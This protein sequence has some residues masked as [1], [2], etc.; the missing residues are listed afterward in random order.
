[1][2]T[3]LIAAAAFFLGVSAGSIEVLFHPHDPALTKTASWIVE[4]RGQIDLAL[5]SLDTHESSPVIQA[6]KA[7]ETR[8]RID[9]GELRVR[10]VFEGYGSK[11]DA[12]RKMQAL[13][14]LGVDVR[15]FARSA[16]MH[17]KFAVIDPEGPRGRVI[18]GSANWSMMSQRNYDENTLYFENEP[19]PLARFRHEFD[20]L[21]A[22]SR[23]FGN[24]G[25]ELPEGPRDFPDQ[26]G[27]AIHFNTTRWIDRESNESRFL[28]GEVIRVIDESR[29]AIDA[30]TTRARHP[31][32]LAALER[33]S[34]R[35]VRVRL[36]I[37][38]DDYRDVWKRSAALLDPVNLILRIKMYNFTPGNFLTRQM[39]HKF[40][41]I[42]DRVLLTGSYNWSLS[43]ENGHVENLVELRDEAAAP[44]MG[45]Y[46]REFD[47][48]WDLGRDRWPAV[49]EE[50]RRLRR[51]GRL[52]R[53]AFAP[54]ALAYAEARALVGSG[55]KCASGP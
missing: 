18:T 8:R 37:G 1:M 6:L 3:I 11:E 43:S 44:V 30:A 46:R 32:I 42:D 2:G 54:M 29:A 45:R 5:Y 35:G 53:C 7:A 38:Q 48:L 23:E 9:G 40:L 47:R 49:L 10:L 16:K 25:P 39:H 26:P 22:Q 34:A 33:A 27:V 31:D 14:D 41:I 20:R 36:L 24:A 13:E 17:H 12:I 19:E 55:R 4:A 51:E 28:A 50:T 52:P 15:E 21:W